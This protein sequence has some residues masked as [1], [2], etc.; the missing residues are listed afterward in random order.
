MSDTWRE[1][2]I[3]EAIQII[4][5]K[6]I[7]QAS[8]DKTIKAVVNRV[9][10]E[11]TGKYQVR[12]QDSLF[13]AYATSSK[14]NYQKDQ[15]VSILI[16]GN[17][18]DRVKTILGG[19]ENKVVT[20]NSIPV[21]S[22]QYNAIGIGGTTLTE[23]IGL[24]SYKPK[25]DIYLFKDGQNGF[26]INTESYKY[27]QKGNSIALRMDIRT[28]LA[29]SQV[30]GN[31]GVIFRLVFKDNVTGQQTIRDFTVQK[32]HVIGQPYSLRAVTP[33]EVLYTDVDTYNFQRI[34]S[35]QAFCQGFPQ[36]DTKTDIKDIKDI[37]ISGIYINGADTLTEQALNGYS[38]HIVDPQGTQI[39]EDLKT[40]TLTAQLKQSG[41]IVTENVQYFWG[42]EDA[43]VFRGAGGEY[44]GYLG[45][46]WKCLNYYDQGLR[47]FIPF[48]SPDFSFT[49]QSTN[50]QGTALASS[51]Y[52]NVKCVAVL[53]G[54]TFSGQI[55]VINTL[56]GEVKII[57][58][59]KTEDDKNKTIYYLDNGNPDL[60]C[61][62]YNETGEKIETGLK[63]QWSIFP[64]IGR[65]QLVADSEGEQ[66]LYKKYEE[67]WN[68]E[69]EKYDRIAENQKEDYA[70]NSENYINAKANFEISQSDPYVYK[71]KYYNFPIK[72]ISG[73]MKISCAAYQGDTYKGTGSITL[74]N[75]NAL[76]G[77]YSLNIENG[78]QVFQYDTKGNSPASKQ[79]DKPLVVQPLNFTLID[80]QGKIVTHEQIRQDGWIK[81]IIPNTQTLLSSLNDAPHDEG[82]TDITVIR[83]DLPLAANRWDVYKNLDQFVFAIDDR[84]DSK[85][86]IN[87]IWLNVKYKDLIL[88]AYTN[89]SF[90]KDGDP[91]TN[92]TDF[93]A[94][95]NPDKT[96]DWVYISNQSNEQM[97]GDD[98]SI[99][100][101][102]N[103][104]L[105]N[106]SKKIQ[107]IQDSSIFWTCPP[108]TKDSPGE[109]NRI[110]YLTYNNSWQTPKIQDSYTSKTLADIRS[111]KPINIVRGQYREGKESGYLKY[112]AE[113]P[114]CTE[115]FKDNGYRIKIKPKTGFKYVVY[116]ED[117]TRPDYDNTL[118]FEIFLQTLEGQYYIADQKPLN[119]EYTWSLIGNLEFDENLQ[120][121]NNIPSTGNK[122]YIKPK[123]NFTGQDLSSAIVV[124]IDQ[125]GFIHIPIYMILNRYGHAALNGWDGNSIQLNKEGNTILA[126]QIGAGHKQDD[127]SYTGVFMGSIKGLESEENKSDAIAK[128]LDK[129]DNKV[130]FM[131][132]H[133]GQRTIFLDAKTGKAE[134]GK[135]NAGR[136]ILDPTQ[137]ISVQVPDKEDPEERDIAL[138]YSGNYPIAD[139]RNTTENGGNFQVYKTGQ[140]NQNRNKDN[141][142]LMIDLSTPQIGFGSGNFTVNKYGHIVAKGGGQIAGWSIS[143]N[144]LAKE[145][146]STSVGIASYGVV[147]NNIGATLPNKNTSVAFW[148]G[149]SQHPNNFYTTHSGFLFSRYGNIAGWTVDEKRLYKSNVGMISDTS[150][151]DGNQYRVQP[152]T[153]YNSEGTPSGTT[154]RAKAFFAGSQSGDRNQSPFYVTH[155]GYFKATSGRIG[156]WLIDENSIYNNNVGLGIKTITGTSMDSAFGTTFGSTASVAA[157][158]WGKSGSSDNTTNFIV[159]NNGTLYSKA[160]KIGGWN[161]TK[162]KLQSSYETNDGQ[163][164]G[165]TLSSNGNITSNWNSKSHTGYSIGSNGIANF[166]QINAN[167]GTIGG[168]E[169]TLNDGIKSTNGTWA[170]HK[171]GLAQFSNIDVTGGVIKLG[172][173]TISAADLKTGR[174]ASFSSGAFTTTGGV[175]GSGATSSTL[176]N[177]VA[178]TGAANSITG[179]DL[180]NYGRKVTADHY[181]TWP[182]VG[183]Q[184]IIAG[185]FT[186]S[187]T[188]I[189]IDNES[190]YTYIDNMGINIH[191]SGTLI[192]G[193]GGIQTSNKKK[194]KTGSI[195][196]SDGSTI[197]VDSGLIVQVN[198]PVGGDLSWN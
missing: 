31:Y 193:G 100:D 30:G 137:K 131:G 67:D 29:S 114:I 63:Y 165:I 95:I 117:G 77:M 89:F 146:G 4:A 75:K 91:G 34:D 81:W 71:N 56:L 3:V 154:W 13:Q 142:G 187:G 168:C 155:N 53:S 43:T 40:I 112:F 39:T 152:V 115:Y 72:S 111:D 27:I 170:I 159:T 98:G 126:P 35:I 59:D 24:S 87:Y 6:K 163:K 54:N 125:I 48:N 128:G 162:N 110:T 33:V 93:I 158:F 84:Y 116:S 188:S 28:D 145:T 79:L 167:Q 127:N 23:Q 198:A 191:S 36:N 151:E 76:E 80:N 180:T 74:Y 164:R 8:F 108:K 10:D 99:V 66:D 103:F 58:S 51:R 104:Q 15:M 172:G 150:T 12:Y 122:R 50:T 173:T 169:I 171:N 32:K 73:S 62:V 130:G 2:A 102:I 177:G 17:D 106:N 197:V 44:S 138:I 82:E 46:G 132:Y 9:L 178:V 139:F 186:P 1:D 183:A 25:G 65:G 148:A 16:P 94:K 109:E 144:K 90:P 182:K 134:F 175:S 18:W 153:N 37:F 14:L 45:D 161:I 129:D 88:D 64:S 86:N 47:A 60:T 196:F 120:S 57:S 185:K 118:P 7:A 85:K 97:F 189:S 149:T 157:R 21:A 38:L 26:F 121:I 92:G 136:I 83:A 22:N 143:D 78:A 192:L 190:N 176:N 55:Q 68:V 179:S 113:I 133:R 19:V 105:Y 147:T 181:A 135:N 123:D 70:N 41:R 140:L 20:Y 194:G 166:Y 184:T 49:S 96:T 61:Q 174:T 42:I 141:K 69:K 160:G 101:K 195:Y 107:S 5:D 119:R 156:S 11:T 52:N 124:Q